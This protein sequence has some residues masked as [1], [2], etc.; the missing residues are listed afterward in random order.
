MLELVALII[1]IIIL[2]GYIYL[3]SKITE[4]FVDSL[5]SDNTP[6]S[7][8]YY[9][10]SCPPGF[11]SFYNNNGDIIC[12]DGDIV[13]NKCLGDKQCTL[14]NTGDGLPNCVDYILADYKQK[15]TSSCSS[16]MPQ[17]FE[18]AATN[19]KGC[20]NGPLNSTLTGPK[21]TSQP[22]CTIYSSMELNQNS[23]NSCYNQQLLDNTQCF[24][25][26]CTKTIEQPQANGPVLIAIGFTDS[27]GMHR[28]AYTRQSMENYLNVTN[29]HWKDS[30]FIDLSKNINVAEV[31][32]A[33]YVDKTMEQSQVQF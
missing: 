9:L 25:T 31:A 1:I 8:T 4:Q 27:T 2:L 15:A 32:K 16:S 13:A 20:T 30:G 12:C 7:Q 10:T 26:N 19:S 3:N 24:G 29:P 18:D 14:G 33:Y 5:Q 28:V 22:S 17:Y 23:K 11:N 6:P 21:M